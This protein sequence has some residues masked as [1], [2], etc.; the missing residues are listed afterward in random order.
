MPQSPKRY[1][2]RLSTGQLTGPEFAAPCV[3]GK[4][5]LIK[6][7]EK[8]EGDK[9]SP[10]GVWP[11]RRALFRADRIAARA[12]QLRLD[13][14]TPDDGW[15]DDPDDMGYNRQIR[16]P[17]RGR[18]ENLTR[19]DRLYDLLVVLGHNDDPPVP[20][21][22][23]AIFLHCQNPDGEPTLGCLALPR[24]ALI[25]LVGRLEPGDEI[26]ITR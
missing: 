2:A 14:I 7:S 20:G 6:A 26:E 22:G 16:K 15:C 25:D 13:A 18:H 5:G 9:A 8:R 3:F 19:E 17:Y 12:T 24:D 23:S 10:I 21:L 11:V 4:A 1:L